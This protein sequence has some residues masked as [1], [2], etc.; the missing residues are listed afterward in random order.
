MMVRFLDRISGKECAAPTSPPLPGQ[1]RVLAEQIEVS[2]AEPGHLGDFLIGD[3]EGKWIAYA[4]ES[5]QV[6]TG[7]FCNC[8]ELPPRETSSLR[9]IGHKANLVIA[10]G[11]GT[12]DWLAISPVVM[13]S[14]AK[15]QSFDLLLVRYLWHL[16]EVCHRPITHLRSEE[17]CLPVG[18]VR[19]A[20]PR[21]PEYLSAHTEDWEYRKIAS[22]VPKRV[23][24]IVSEELYDIYENRLAVRLVDKL[25]DYLR[26]RC[27]ELSKIEQWFDPSGSYTGTHWRAR[28][29]SEL[30]AEAVN[31]EVNETKRIV[32]EAKRTLDRLYR[33]VMALHDSP[34][35]KAMPHGGWQPHGL[36]ETNIL[37]NDRHYQYV[38]LLW[39]KCLK[40]EYGRRRSRREQYDEAQEA[41]RGFDS[42]CLLLA[43]RG[44][45]LLGY[46]PEGDKPCV[47][48]RPVAWSR[49]S[50]PAQLQWNHDGTI[51][52][53]GDGADSGV[54]FVPLAAPLT[55]QSRP[56]VT[57]Q[58]RTT[59]SQSLSARLNGN[60]SATGGHPSIGKDLVVL[61]YPGDGRERSSLPSPIRHK[62]MTLGNDLHAPESVAFLPVSSYE[63][64]TLERVGRALQ[65]ALVRPQLLTYPPKVF[66]PEN[67]KDLLAVA[68]WVVPSSERG[69]AAIVRVPSEEEKHRLDGALR[70]KLGPLRSIGKKVQQKIDWLTKF[71]TELDASYTCFEGILQCPVC[72]KHN[73]PSALRANLG[74]HFVCKCGQCHS[75][76]G[77]RACG[78]CG[79]RYPFISPSGAWVCSG[80]P[81]AGWVDTVYGLDI[82]AVPCWAANCAD[83]YIC[84]D[85]GACGNAGRADCGSCTRC[86]SA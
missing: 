31:S 68:D 11:G 73:D 54:L 14:R 8:G 30:L 1:Y 40:T 18:R 49:G 50:A 67:V 85:C 65:W 33:E 78:K 42:F 59:I 29:I 46:A 32:N 45:K 2:Q 17:I 47:Q 79:S 57:E 86:A 43:L 3:E 41:N 9:E 55:S 12:L 37:V 22:V 48:G 80:T 25:L 13:G 64:D 61:L 6:L 26:Q 84:P 66:L 38:A 24:A 77:T 83:T 27:E 19:R 75:L 35:Y 70:A 72:W 7:P 53:Q 52:I 63:L 5:G 23:R 15:L 81:E 60:R 62:V 36:Q 69:R 82:L 4:D 74:G 34:L 16:Q 20:S 51:K 56:D 28:R 58:L 21:A 39:Q 76:W 44:M 10:Q 71:K